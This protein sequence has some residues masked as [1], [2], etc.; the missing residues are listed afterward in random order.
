MQRYLTRRNVRLSEMEPYARDLRAGYNGRVRNRGM[1]GLVVWV[2][3]GVVAAAYGDPGWQTLFNGRSLDG[4]SVSAPVADREAGFW[5]VTDGVIE[6]NSMG[7]RKHE[8]VWL[9]SDREYTNFHLRV[10][11][12]VF[13]NSPGNSG[14]QFRSR[15]V[16]GTMYGPQV[17]IHAPTPLRTGLIYDETKGVN[18]WIHP[19]LPNWNMVA[20]KAPE[21]ARSTTLKYADQDPSAWNSL[22]L[23][24]DGMHV[25][26]KVNGRTIT[27]F[28]ATGTLDDTIHREAQVGIAGRIALQLHRGDQLKIRFRAL[29]IRELTP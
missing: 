5:K 16:G 6:C 10:E 28:D 12:Q 2:A 25:T 4:W 22:E 26:T 19:S 14:I 20:A 17:D 1:L 7:R 8:Y 23:V 18:R 27:D 9:L 13:T 24:A 15:V 21:A 29:E 11:F 3:A